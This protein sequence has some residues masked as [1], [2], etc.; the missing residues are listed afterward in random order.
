MSDVYCD[1]LTAIKCTINDNWINN[2]KSY[3]WCCKLSE[4]YKIWPNKKQLSCQFMHTNEGHHELYQFNKICMIGLIA[5]NTKYWSSNFNEI[6][7]FK[8]MNQQQ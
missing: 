5:K 4:H 1:N 3:K 6:F 8:G 7:W 2:I